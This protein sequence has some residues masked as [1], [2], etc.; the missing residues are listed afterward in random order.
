M[1]RLAI[2][3]G[4]VILVT[5]CGLLPEVAHQ[6]TIHNPFPQLT[7]IAVA[8]FVNLSAEPTV[9]GR[10]FGIAYFGELQAIQ[11]FEVVP[12]GVVEA[13]IRENHISLNT[14]ADV[15]RLAQLLE[16]DAVVLGAV[17]DYSPYYPPRCGLQVEWYAANPCFHPIPPGYGLPWG[18][19]AEED[20]PE[21]LVMETE[22][23]LAREQLKTQTPDYKTSKDAPVAA[24]A[25][26]ARPARRADGVLLAGGESAGARQS[27][28]GAQARADG[29]ASAPVNPNPTGPDA[30]SVSASRTRAAGETI[31]PGDHGM[32]SMLVPPVARSVL[33]GGPEIGL[34]GLPPDWPDPR[35]L[36]PPPPSRR[37]PGCFPTSEPV[38]RHTKMYS[39]TDPDFTAALSNYSTFRDD[40]RFG[41][42]SGYL[43]RS[44][45]F[46]RFCCHKHIAEMLTARGGAGTTRVLW[47]WPDSRYTP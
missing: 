35:G 1:M 22:M 39:G 47:R 46:I 26:R 44:E 19:P 3:C 45:D 25:E 13:A 27:A 11:G 2:A 15:R 43:Q 10:Q 28:D 16:V 37:R 30:T 5:G 32:G 29:K 4:V 17:T 33:V 38:L 7:K 34:S 24:P 40:A 41:G 14:P 31:V 8:P 6:P 9:D 12:I 42:W 23:S 21:P 18:T 20:I 36:V